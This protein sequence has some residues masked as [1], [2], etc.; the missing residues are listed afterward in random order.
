VVGGV[1]NGVLETTGVLEVQVELA[2]LAAVGGG[3]ARANSRP[4][5]IEAISNDL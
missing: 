3:G 1:N 5:L 2:V 4:T